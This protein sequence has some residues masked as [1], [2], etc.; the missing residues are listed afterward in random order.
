MDFFI[1]KIFPVFFVL[2]IR[3]VSAQ[4]AFYKVN[5]A[6]IAHL[7]EHVIFQEEE[8]SNGIAGEMLMILTADSGRV[9]DVIL[10]KGLTSS[11]NEE[12]IRACR[13][14]NLPAVAIDNRFTIMLY[15]DSRLKRISPIL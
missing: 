8:I 2:T 9:T 5:Q 10:K 4:S 14:F 6:L 11:I 7:N 1:R 12:I 13:E 3:H 15:V